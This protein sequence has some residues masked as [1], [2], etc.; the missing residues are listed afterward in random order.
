MA[1]WVFKALHRLIGW[2]RT[3]EEEEQALRAQEEL[4][5]EKESR[6]IDEAEVR[7]RIGMRWPR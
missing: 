5:Q 7:T 2:P 6:A 3:P 1:S 4:R